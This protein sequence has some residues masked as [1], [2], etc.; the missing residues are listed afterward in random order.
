MAKRSAEIIAVGALWLAVAAPS[1]AV[2]VS[3][4]GLFPNKAIVTIDGGRPRTLSVGDPAL[5]NVRLI[6][7]TPDVAVLEIDGKRRTLGIGQGVYSALQPRGHPVVTLNADSTGH[8]LTTG[9]INGGTVKFLVD[10]GATMVSLGASDAKRLGIDYEKGQRGTSN[11]A[12]GIASVYR[13]KLDAVKVGNIALTN[14]DGVVH[15]SS[16]MPFVLLGMSFLGRL[17]IRQDG[18]QMTMMQKY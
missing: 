3:V 4:V 15:E 11:T 13:V 7:A 18:Q 2:D 14:V 12:N 16:D 10:T 8:Y 9:S 5:N 1:L 6:S 17:E